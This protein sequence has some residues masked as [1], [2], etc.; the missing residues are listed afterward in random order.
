VLFV[1]AYEPPPDDRSPQARQLRVAVEAARQSDLR[2]VPLPWPYPAADDVLPDHLPGD[3][4]AYCGP[5]PQRPEHYA[6]LERALATRGVRLVNTASASEQATR[7]ERWHELLGELTARTVI[8]RGPADLPAAGSLGLP[9][10]VKGLVKSAKELGLEACLA[11]DAQA[12][13]QRARSAWKR[14]QTVV[15]REYLPLRYTGETV[16]GFPHG[17]EYRFILLDRVVLSRAFYWDGP[18]PFASSFH[19]DA[20]PAAL[21][22]AAAERLDARLLAVDIGQLQDGSWRVIEVGDA[23]H[24][25][26]GHIAPHLYWTKLRERLG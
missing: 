9:L 22:V 11:R 3:L 16:M 1:V 25:A 5:I 24:T 13:E 14:E 26:L 10:F 8:L 2:V 4:A 21:A 20:P 19:D 6:S 7:I 12:L 17:R 18:D 23:Q 15:A